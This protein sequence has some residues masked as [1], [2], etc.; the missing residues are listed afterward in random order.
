MVEGVSKRIRFDDLKLFCR[1]AYMK[2]GVPEREA[3][4]VADLLARADLRGVETHGVTRLP[5]YIQRLQKGY[6][7]AECKITS[8]KD[9]GPVGFAEAH[10]SMGHV[11]AYKAMHQAIEKAEEHGIGCVSVKDSGHFGVAGVFP[12]MAAERG[13]IGYICTNSAPM[14]APFG[15]RERIIGNNPLSYAFPAGTYPPVVVDFSCSVVSSGKLILARKK[16]EKIPIGWAFDKDGL[17]T[18]DPYEGYEGGGSLT[19]VGAHKGYGLTMAHEILTAVLTG[20]KWTRNIKSLYEEDK[21]GIQGTCHS[22][23]ALDP[24]CF[25]GR[26]EFKQNMDRYIKSIKESGKAKNVEEILIPGEPEFRTE[27]KR[28]KEGI[29]L[30]LNTAEE[31]TTLGKSFDLSLP[32]IE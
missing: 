31:L 6:V 1:Q 27:S 20:G 25:I 19:P 10:G 23:M 29:P 18:Q 26:E 9:K 17:P 15:G 22:F 5:I 12:E 32:F 7:R 3:C 8:I 2:A 21:S 11:V 4:I 16:G 24:D 13:I 30:S 14:M 28:L